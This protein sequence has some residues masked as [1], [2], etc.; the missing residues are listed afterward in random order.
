[1]RGFSSERTELKNKELSRHRFLAQKTCKT[2]TVGFEISVH[3]V[4][5][6]RPSMP[7]N[8]VKLSFFLAQRIAVIAVEAKCGRKI[9]EK[10][11][12]P[13]HN[14][15]FCFEVTIMGGDRGGK[16]LNSS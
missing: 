13:C 15:A 6:P 11:T 10:G 3:L 5:Q 16:A 7:W 12:Q 2:S 8:C 4:A 1:M 9:R 14:V